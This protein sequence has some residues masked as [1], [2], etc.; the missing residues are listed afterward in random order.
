MSSEDEYDEGYDSIED[1]SID[2]SAI[3]NF[4]SEIKVFKN[5]YFKINII[6]SY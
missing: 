4:T 6:I 1:D 3:P 2:Q 5:Q